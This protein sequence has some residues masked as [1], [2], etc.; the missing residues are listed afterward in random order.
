M[1]YGLDKLLA[2]NT[3]PCYPC[4]LHIESIIQYDKICISAKVQSTLL[5]LY[6]QS[7]GRVQGRYFQGFHKRAPGAPLEELDTGVERCDAA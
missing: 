1:E 5:L 3:L 7:C 4:T 2:I 6:T